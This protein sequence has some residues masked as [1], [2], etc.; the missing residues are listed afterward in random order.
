MK[1]LSVFILSLLLLGNISIFSQPAQGEPRGERIKNVLKLTSEQE[2]K[3]NELKIQQQQAVIDT[4]AKIQKNRLELKQMIDAGKIDEKNFLQITDDNIKLQGDIKYSATKHWLD[5]YK[6]LN[7][8]QK[9]IWTKHLAR[10][11]D[12]G[13]M[14]ARMKAGFQNPMRERG[15]RKMMGRQ[16]GMHR[17]F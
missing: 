12:P 14:K 7:D 11:T 10:M 15:I 9:A 3:F 2:K 6:M 8:D 16:R 13:A 5:V 1:K 4:R 17:D